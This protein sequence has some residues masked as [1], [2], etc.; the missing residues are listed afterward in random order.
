VFCKE[1]LYAEEKEI[2][3]N[4]TLQSKKTVGKKDKQSMKHA[5]QMAILLLV[6]K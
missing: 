2:R 6:L 1:Q 4:K 5:M 3:N